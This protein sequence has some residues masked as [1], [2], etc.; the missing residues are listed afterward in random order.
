M[1]V[2]DGRT[3]RQTDSTITVCLGWNIVASCMHACSDKTAH[4]ELSTAVMQTEAKQEFIN[5]VV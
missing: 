3:D 2:T 5:H 1:F 4:S